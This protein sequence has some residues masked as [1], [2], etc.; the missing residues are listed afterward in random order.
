MACALRTALSS[1]L[2]IE[3]EKDMVVVLDMAGIQ[4]RLSVPLDRTASSYVASKNSCCSSSSLY[5]IFC[6][7]R[8]QR[9]WMK[10]AS[11]TY[12]TAAND[13]T[14]HLYARRCQSYA[15]GGDAAANESRGQKSP[16]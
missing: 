14:V 7:S 15:R 4:A 16:C 1:A 5:T 6:D 12:G 13:Q 3:P 8:G 10:S 9:G 2:A 11:F